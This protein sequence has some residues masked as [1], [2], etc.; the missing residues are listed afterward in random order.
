MNYQ[1]LETHF[2]A[3]LPT[4]D[5]WNVALLALGAMALAYVVVLT[6]LWARSRIQ[7]AKAAATNSRRIAARRYHERSWS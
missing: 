4:G 7:A 2:L 1:Q 6:I 3:L 5:G